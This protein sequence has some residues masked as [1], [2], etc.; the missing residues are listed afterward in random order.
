[1]RLS[2]KV[3]QE[4]LEN[5]K[6]TESWLFLPSVLEGQMKR[7]MLL[8]DLKRRCLVSFESGLAL[9]TINQGLPVVPFWSDRIHQRLR[10]NLRTFKGQV[11]LRICK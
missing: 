3:C 9:E 8:L 10:E 6:A 1:M 4:I 7:F 2:F 5:L 11:D